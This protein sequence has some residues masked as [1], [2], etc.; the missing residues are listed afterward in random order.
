MSSSDAGAIPLASAD[1]H[2][3]AVRWADEAGALLLA[4][5]EEL[6]YEGSATLK[7][8]GDRRAHDL[9]V[10]RLAEERPDDAVLSE[11][12]RDNAERLTSARTWIVDPLDGTRAGQNAF[13]ARRSITIESLPPENSMAGRSNSAATSRMMW[14]ASASRARRC[15]SW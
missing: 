13:S 15:E 3:L 14:M 2:A 1:D 4:L 8:E 7:R 10:A 9:L 6:Q 12:G 11:E 5:R